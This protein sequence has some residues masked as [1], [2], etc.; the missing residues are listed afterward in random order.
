[1]VSP[2]KKLKKGQTCKV[3]VTLPKGTASNVLKYSS[4]NKKVVTVNS[5]GV[6]KAKKKG[7]AYIKVTTFNKITKKVKVTVK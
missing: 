6:V 1:M 5:K 2:K 3:K 4:S 7:T